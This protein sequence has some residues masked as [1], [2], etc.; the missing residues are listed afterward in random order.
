[1]WY[2][3][4]RQLYSATM[5]KTSDLLHIYMDF[6]YDESEGDVLRNDLSI[7]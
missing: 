1:M 5:P 3:L 2:Q 6:L 4:G 7:W